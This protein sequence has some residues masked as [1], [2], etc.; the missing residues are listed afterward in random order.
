MTKRKRQRRSSHERNR[1]TVQQQF[2]HNTRNTQFNG[3]TLLLENGCSDDEILHTIFSSLSRGIWFRL[4]GK[5]EKYDNIYENLGIPEAYL[6]PFLIRTKILRDYN[7]KT[8]VNK[9]VLAQYCRHNSFLE[10]TKYKSNGDTTIYIINKLNTNEYYK[11]PEVQQKDEYFEYPIS[12]KLSTKI[13][14]IKDTLKHQYQKN[15]TTTTTIINTSNIY[16]TKERKKEIHPSDTISIVNH[17]NHEQFIDDHHLDE[18][19]NNPPETNP[20]TNPSTNPDT[21]DSNPTT[22]PQSIPNT[23]PSKFSELIHFA[24]NL[25]FER[26]PRL[27]RNSVTD[28]EIHIGKSKSKSNDKANIVSIYHLLKAN[29]SNNYSNKQIMKTANNIVCYDAGYE[30][31][32]SPRCVYRFV[33]ELELSLLSNVSSFNPKARHGSTSYTD[34]IEKLHPGLLHSLFRYVTDVQG[35]N[36]SFQELSYYMNL[37]SQSNPDASQHLHLN[38]KQVSAWFKK[39]KGKEVSPIERPLETE[40]NIE[41]RKKWIA[42]YFSILTD[43]SKPVVYLDEKWFYTTSRRKKLK[44]LPQGSCELEPPPNLKRFQARNRRFPVKC[45]FMGVVARPNEQR[46][47]NGR[48]M[49]KRVSKSKIITKRTAHKNFSQ[50]RLTNQMIKDGDWKQLIPADGMYISDLK[51]LFEESYQLEEYIME[52]L[53]FSIL[54]A[55]RKRQVLNDTYLVTNENIEVKV[56]HKVNDLVEE[57]CSCDSAFMSQ[58]MREVGQRIRQEM[59]WVPMNETIFL[60]MDN[61]GGHG[62]GQTINEYVLYLKNT[63]NITIIHQCPRSPCTNTL[64]LGIWFTLQHQV[65]KEHKQMR[66]E[67]NALAASVHKIW[68]ESPITTQLSNVFEKVSD[69]AKIIVKCHGS[70][71]HCESYYRGKSRDQLILTEEDIQNLDSWRAV[72]EDEV[73]NDVIVDIDD[74]DDDDSVEEL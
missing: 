31:P 7:S 69:I 66:I 33:E 38:R 5:E 8:I 34:T 17:D 25:D 64:D 18:K 59:H 30:K 1:C 15:I 35:S 45:M 70:I 10:Y 27:K 2:K 21:P 60:V 65:E 28:D 49:L 36:L 46:K 42:K 71:K 13:Q 6:V 54:L 26:R 41:E 23:T 73:V 53:E 58:A 63:F 74:D 22:I 68:H 11:N 51:D 20:T 4:I 3:A 24:L 47:F 39:N 57:D 56:R 12:T 32:Y 72:D 16:D 52:R 40:K 61:A 9:D 67:V 19:A 37:K 55:N 48:I 29:D 50:D 43:P 62:N 14:L 44:Q